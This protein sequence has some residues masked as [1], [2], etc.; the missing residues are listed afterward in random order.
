MKALCPKVWTTTKASL[1]YVISCCLRKVVSNTCC[2]VGFVFTL[3]SVCPP[4][5][6]CVHLV[7]CVPPFVLCAHLVFCVPILCFVCPPCVLCA[8]L[9]FCVPTL[10]CVCPPC[11]LCAHLVLCVPTLCS[12]CPPCVLCAQCCQFLCLF[13][14]ALTFIF[15]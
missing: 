12:V 14:I 5:V 11:V 6:L 13:L 4:C 10:C 2:V 3:C 8:H 7:F 15:L 1:I 9:V